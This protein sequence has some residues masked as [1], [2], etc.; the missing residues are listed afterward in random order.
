MLS[1]GQ[2]KPVY[3]GFF[4]D[5]VIYDSEYAGFTEKQN[6]IQERIK[7]NT[8]YL[9]GLVMF[10]DLQ[11]R[12]NV[13]KRYQPHYITNVR[14]VDFIPE[15]EN[16]N[17]E[18]MIGDAYLEAEKNIAPAWKIVALSGE[19]SSSTDSDTKNLFNIPQVN[20]EANYRKTIQPL[21]YTPSLTEE[22]YR[23]LIN[24]TPAF[25]DGQVVALLS[26]DVMIYAE[27]LNTMLL[28]DNFDIEVYEVVEDAL[29]SAHPWTSPSSIKKDMFKRKYFKQDYG[30]IM[31]GV[32][33]PFESTY[34]EEMQTMQTMQS[35][36][37]EDSVNKYFNFLV[38]DM[39]DEKEACRGASVFN[40]DSYYID[41]DFDCETEIDSDIPIIDIYGVVT[42][43]EIC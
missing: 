30:K 5:N 19:I 31:G 15:T 36:I 9:E 26:E 34:N 21:S 28:T 4:D 33:S 8:Q 2:L 6:S 7:E 1:V 16:F 13:F 27:E 40:K 35:Q 32:M 18:R 23:K 14:S 37:T 29:P 39:V 25:S 41:L 42:E 10:E 12:P 43:P 20:I 22:K 11:D 38:D 3:Y 17:Y 24:T